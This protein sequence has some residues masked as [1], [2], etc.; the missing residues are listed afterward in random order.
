[1]SVSWAWCGHESGRGI[2][3]SSIPVGLATAR[4]RV[5]P[6]E[7]D[8]PRAFNRQTLTKFVVRFGPT[9]PHATAPQDVGL[10]LA[11]CERELDVIRRHAAR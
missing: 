10:L 4:D 3:R 9:T 7:L 8:V 2:G 5:V 11:R 6:V 1:M